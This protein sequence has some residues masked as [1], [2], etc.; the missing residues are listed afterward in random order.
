MH[1]VILACSRKE[2][3]TI[4]RQ[5]ESGEPLAVVGGRPGEEGVAFHPV[6]VEGHRAETEGR[7][8]YK[9]WIRIVRYNETGMRACIHW[10]RHRHI[11]SE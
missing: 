7:K 8:E 5:A 6:V 3:A 4:I 1:T 11:D 9:L 2:K 10:H